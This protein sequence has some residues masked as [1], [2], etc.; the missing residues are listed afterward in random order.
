MNNTYKIKLESPLLREGLTIETE[1]SE[2]Y[3]SEVTKKCLDIVREINKP[4]KIDLTSKIEG[5]NLNIS[6][7]GIECN[8]DGGITGTAL[9]P[10]SWKIELN[11]K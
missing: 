10:S 7:D 6:A 2:K 5:H 4:E 1:C 8:F 11:D 9:S 3:V